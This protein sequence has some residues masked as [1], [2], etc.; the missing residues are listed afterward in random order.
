MNRTNTLVIEEHDFE[1]V[2][3][4]MENEV[5]KTPAKKALADETG[6][7]IELL[8][9]DYQPDFDLTKVDTEPKILHEMLQLS[10]EE[11]V[12]YFEFVNIKPIGIGATAGHGS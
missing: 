12:V 4:L 3:N 2:L 9:S 7:G 5:I 10:E 1:Y 8:K 11:K 6:N